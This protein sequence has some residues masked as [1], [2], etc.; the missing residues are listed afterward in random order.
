MPQPPAAEV[1][2]DQAAQIYDAERNLRWFPAL[3]VLEFAKIQQYVDEVYSDRW[4]KARHPR[5]ARPTVVPGV[6]GNNGYSVGNT[7]GFPSPGGAYNFNVLHEV[8]HQ[9]T[10]N[11]G[12]TPK[13]AAV[14]VELVGR[15]MGERDANILRELYRDRGDDFG[16]RR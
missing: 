7:I 16:E 12:H 8:A 13:F 14:L 9:L 10:R 6:H 15:F 1:R 5:A 4:F 11:E 3:R 2:F